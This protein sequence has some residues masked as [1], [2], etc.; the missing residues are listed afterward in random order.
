M[1]QDQIWGSNVMN[2]AEQCGH[3]PC[4][5]DINVAG[6]KRFL[7]CRSQN[8]ENNPTHLKCSGFVQATDDKD[9]EQISRV[10]C[11]LLTD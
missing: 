7:I 2:T 3:Y 5:D 6:N 11:S 9:N 4:I 10:E 8:V 1:G